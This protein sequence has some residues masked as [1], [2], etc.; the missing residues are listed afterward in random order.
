MPTVA[1]ILAHGLEHHLA[2]RLDQ[3]ER[4]YR[5]VVAFDAA[6]P[7]ALHL[8]AMLAHQRGQAA[9]A[10]SFGERAIAADGTAASYR[11]T[12]G[13]IHE[14]AGRLD[15]AIATFRAAV[16]MAP[17]S[18][19]CRYR[20]GAAL[21]AS[22][23]IE[24]AVD[25]LA[26]AARLAP[27]MVEALAQLGQALWRLGKIEQAR[28]AL[29]AARASLDVTQPV[30]RSV[31]ARLF[32]TLAKVEE[33][34]G[35]LEEV[36]ELFLRALVFDPG[37]AEAH[38]DAAILLLLQGVIEPALSHYRAAI[39]LRPEDP[40]LHSNLLYALSFVPDADPDA[41]F[42]E[43]RRWEDRHARPHY[44]LA[45]SHDN[46]RDPDR[47]LRIGYLSADLT[48]HPITY[49]IEGLIRRHDRARF[50]VF[51][52]SD[53]VGDAADATTA[54]LKGLVEAW[55]DT[56]GVPDTEIAEAIRADGIDILIGLAGHT[57]FNRLTI[58]AHKPAPIQISYG[59][60]T[61]GMTAIDYWLT[62]AVL[63]PLDTAERCAET[64]WRLP[65]LVIHQP[66]PEAPDVGPAPYASTGWITFASF[67]NPAK[68][69]DRAVAL[70][71]RILRELPDSRLRLKYMDWLD[72]PA[73]AR[74]VRACFAAHGIDGARLLLDGG[75]MVRRQHLAL[76]G[77]SDI[78]L[79][80]FPFNGWTTTF[81]AL[82]MGVPVVT[83]AG[84]RF[85]GR[86]GASFLTA[87][88]HPELIAEDAGGYVAIAVKLA[89]DRDRLAH[90]RASL[91][92]EVASSP[93][94]DADA[95][96]RAVE[97]AYRQ[98]WRLWCERS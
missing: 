16:A 82:W 23:R 27:G 67:N 6:Q 81:E 93:L 83:L 68:L 85:L 94:C 30:D 20:L 63:H 31:A 95:Y 40:F 14:S 15:L 62:D 3:A 76:V 53:V 19:D 52:Y 80:S 50:D 88:G 5:Q 29:L 64:L 69:T 42:A 2:G 33:H 72:R 71:S 58:L 1:E 91:R 75:V 47:K 59:V 21:F 77:A 65:N 98:M 34:L 8:L 73:L 41:V 17:A 10:L 97:A 28:V 36:V 60:G 78:M 90:V 61:T 4:V 51:C 70:W 12:L 84:D 11:V 45:R 87:A 86:V 26:E 13:T 92:A 37:M 38:N 46:L 79:D 48:T 18:A 44:R 35:G 56:A 96:T 49:N 57:A 74:R 66:P 39:A 54:R 25:E 89:Q 7:D 32:F 55:R 43:H 24:A 22:G 9:T